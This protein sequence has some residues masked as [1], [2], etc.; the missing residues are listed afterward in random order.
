MVL[1]PK[2]IVLIFGTFS[3]KLLFLLNI[4]YPHISYGTPIPL[5][6]LLVSKYQ[7]GIKK[8]TNSSKKVP[9][10]E[11]SYKK[12]KNYKKKLQ[13]SQKNAAIIKSSVEKYPN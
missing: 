13:K 3:K 2:K 1:F 7:K 12:L 11:I 10:I 6:Y 5:W 8:G 9:K 4:N